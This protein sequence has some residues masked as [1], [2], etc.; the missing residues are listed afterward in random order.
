MSAYQ[1]V[2][3]G[4]GLVGSSLAFGLARQGMSVALLDEHDLALR[5]SRGN[6]GLVWVQ[7]KGK[8]FPPYARWSRRASE[9]W[10][11]LAAELAEL[12]GIDV[13]YSRSGGVLVALDETELRGYEDLLSALREES[14]NHGYDYEVLDRAALAELLPGIGPE[15]PGGTYCPH[16]GHAN[17]L[18]LL[19]ALH[20]GF[21]SHGGTYLPG[22]GANAV[23]A[24]A[25]GFEIATD[26]GVVAGERV[27]I[28]AGLGS[29]PLAEALGLRIP[30]T[31]L[32]GQLMVTERAAPRFDVPTNLVRQTREG[33]FMLGYS[34]EDLGFD[35]RTSTRTLRDVAWRCSRA[36]PFLGD[37]RVVRTWAALRIM[38]PDGFPIYERSERHP[39]AWAATCHSGVTLAANHALEVSAWI[40]ADRIPEEHGCFSSRRLD[41][42]PAA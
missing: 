6:F 2:V 8:G 30:V 35:T 16:D 26:A 24:R 22:R 17:P 37:L 27:V 11:E 32:Q 25:G 21:V 7:G 9:L 36:F 40:A 13:G 20:A 28:A 31:P 42:P 18:L 10:P 1:V 5:A 4:G 12:T 23:E 19:R 15:V 38:T 41:V 34:Q 3:V 14:G 33:S 39:G 29:P